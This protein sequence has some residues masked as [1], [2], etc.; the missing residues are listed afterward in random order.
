MDEKIDSFIVWGPSKIR[1]F[2]FNERESYFSEEKYKTGFLV[3][4]EIIIGACF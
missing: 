4:Q 2:T 3:D 1:E